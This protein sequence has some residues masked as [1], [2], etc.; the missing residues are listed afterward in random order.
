MTSL[1]KQI[2]DLTESQKSAPDD[3]KAAIKS[4]SDGLDSLARTLNRQEPL[5]FAGAPLADEPEPLVPRARGIYFALGGITAAPTAQ[6]RELLARIQKEMDA[7]V[8][9]VN[10]VVEK[11]I[12]DLNRQLADRGVGRLDAG[13]RIP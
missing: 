5:G 1:K 4:V 9:A 7:A 8:Q 6:Q 2:A 3:V 11:T 10:T 13:K 12:P